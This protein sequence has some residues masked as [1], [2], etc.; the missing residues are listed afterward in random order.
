MRLRSLKYLAA[1]ALLMPLAAHAQ[2]YAPSADRILSDPLYLPLQGQIYGNSDYSWATTTQDVFNAAG[3]ETE[4]QRTV[5][6]TLDQQVEYGVTD[7]LALN[8]EMG[9]DP[10]VTTKTDPVAAASFSRNEQ[11]WTDPDFGLVYRVLD[12]RNNP[13][14]LDLRGSYSPDA[15][16]AKSATDTDDGSV[17]RGGRAIDLGAT[18]G[19]E[20]RGFT[21]AGTFDAVFD[22]RR[23]V[24]NQSTGFNTS[25]SSDW[26]YELGLA[27]QTRFTDRFSL[28]AGAGYDFGHDADVLNEGTAVTHSTHAGGTANL[29][30]ALNYHFIPNILVGSVEYQHDF[31][32]GTNNVYSAVPADD[33]A[34]HN[35]SEDLVGVKLRYVLQ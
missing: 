7:D 1:T 2:N 30:A 27:T 18:L 15:F 21:I 9:Y 34:I 6:N 20:T 4:L 16:R 35:K 29:N 33:N 24:E 23:D 14:S 5:S 10:S 13:V 22:G 17:A 19:H 31:D 11:G 26:V 32:G 8:F 25:T 12:E 28:N 3:I